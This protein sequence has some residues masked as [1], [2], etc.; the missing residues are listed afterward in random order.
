MKALMIKIYL[1][2]E[3]KINGS[4]TWEYIVDSCKKRDIAGV[5]VYKAVAGMGDHKELHTF[6]ILSI[7]QN[8]P[9]VVEIIDSRIKIDKLIEELKDDIKEGILVKQEVDVLNFKEL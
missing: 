9:I 7:S 4:A 2:S 6:N 1:D 3:D 8:L 5:T